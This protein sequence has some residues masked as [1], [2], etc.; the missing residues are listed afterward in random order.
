[1]KVKKSKGI[2]PS[3]RKAIDSMYTDVC[4]ICTNYSLLS[5]KEKCF[6]LNIVKHKIKEER[7]LLLILEFQI[8]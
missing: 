6:V 5:K 7:L 1:M 3:H 2:N 8:V 4:G